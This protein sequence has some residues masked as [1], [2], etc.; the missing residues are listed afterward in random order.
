MGRWTLAP[1]RWTLHKVQGSHGDI[2]R[3]AVTPR[4]AS[5]PDRIERASIESLALGRRRLDP[6]VEEGA[7]RRSSRW[8]E[9]ILRPSLAA[10]GHRACLDTTVTDCFHF[11]LSI[12]AVGSAGGC[13]S[14]FWAGE[15]NR[16]RC[17]LLGGTTRV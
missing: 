6:A 15:R 2:G 7:V 16:C 3:T 13:E 8:H 1:S 11:L 17:S 14:A 4:P 5:N 9:G 12:C 10:K